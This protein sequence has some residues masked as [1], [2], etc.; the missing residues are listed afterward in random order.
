MDRIWSRSNYSE[1]PCRDREEGSSCI[2]I[3]RTSRTCTSF[4]G[5]ESYRPRLL[6][7]K[8]VENDRSIAIGLPVIAS[9]H[10]GIIVLF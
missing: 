6:R 5:R 4:E 3:T 7:D 10:R 2:A 1:C 9:I 8:R